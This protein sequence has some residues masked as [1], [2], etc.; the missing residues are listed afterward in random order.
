MKIQTIATI[1]PMEEFIT[2]ND[3]IKQYNNLCIQCTELKIGRK[4][5]EQDQLINCS[6]HE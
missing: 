6:K 2:M 5:V 3:I 4:L 1:Q